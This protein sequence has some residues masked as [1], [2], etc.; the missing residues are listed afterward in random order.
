MVNR[1]SNGGVL[2]AKLE[3]MLRHGEQRMSTFEGAAIPF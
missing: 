1:T 2:K 3:R